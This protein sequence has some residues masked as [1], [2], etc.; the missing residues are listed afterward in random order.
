MEWFAYGPVLRTLRVDPSNKVNL[1][2]LLKDI[3]VGFHI[4]WVASFVTYLWRFHD[5]KEQLG[6]NLPGSDKDLSPKEY[7][8]DIP[9]TFS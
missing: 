5:R 8:E 4:V 9:C 1:F 3:L 2:F 6:S 7:T